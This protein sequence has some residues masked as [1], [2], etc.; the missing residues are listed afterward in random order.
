[1]KRVIDR[2]PAEGEARDSCDGDERFGDHRA[3]H[4]GFTP[5][6]QQLTVKTGIRSNCP[7]HCRISVAVSPSALTP[8]TFS[9]GSTL[10]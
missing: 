9:A 6:G 4:Y 7:I 10:Y 3:V 2:A 5:T 1:M 8:W